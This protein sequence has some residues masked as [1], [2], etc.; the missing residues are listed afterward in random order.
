MELHERVRSDV[1][2]ALIGWNLAAARALHQY[3][4]PVGDT[5]AP[6]AAPVPAPAG[7]PALAGAAPAATRP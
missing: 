3:P 2:D 1:F 4:G 7:A 5:G 6:G